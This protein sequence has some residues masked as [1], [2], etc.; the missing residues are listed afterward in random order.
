MIDATLQTGERYGLQW[1]GTPV[2]CRAAVPMLEMADFYAEH[3][4]LVAPL[5]R[6]E[7]Y[8]LVTREAL[9]AGRWVVASASDALADP[10]RHG[11][12]GHSMP[13]GDADALLQVLQQL[14]GEQSFN[15]SPRIERTGVGAEPAVSGR[16]ARLAG[17]SGLGPQ[18]AA[19]SRRCST[20]HCTRV[21]QACWR[22]QQRP[23]R[24]WISWKGGR[25]VGWLRSRTK[26]PGRSSSSTLAGRG[27][28]AG[29]V[30]A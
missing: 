13:P 24:Q 20:S 8:G 3:D 16:T 25:S 18:A 14:C 23:P 19:V 12:N 27:A 7:S 22:T 1:N 6:P 4:V 10:I 9:T 26:L 15:P 29:V 17:L 5:I 21:P 30:V 2:G 28:G 11:V